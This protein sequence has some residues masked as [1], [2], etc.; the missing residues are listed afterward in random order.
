MI[1]RNI[2]SELLELLAITPTVAILGPRQ[3]GKTTLVKILEKQFSRRTIY[4]D[5][6]SPQDQI[7]LKDAEK[8]LA[9]QDQFLVIIDE[10]QRM[11]ELFPLLR[12]LIDR[13]REDGRFILLGSASPE[14]LFKSAESL[15]GRISYLELQSLHWGEV[16]ELY[17][18]YH[19]WFRGGFPK[20]LLIEKDSSFLRL[21]NDF[22]K[23]YTER[24][25]PLL[26]LNISSITIRNL[27]R[28]LTS[29]HGNLL[30]LSDLSRSLGVSAPTANNYIN[31][32]ENAFLIRRL[33][34]YF[35]NINKRIV[36]MPKVYFRDS[37][38]LH[39]LA[40]IPNME[41][42][43]GWQFVGHSWEGYV[44]QQIIAQ[45]PFNITPYFY[46]T[47]DGTEL[48]L[49]LVK[50]IAPFVGFEIKYTN[51]P[52]LTKGTYIAQKDLGNIP[53][54]VVTPSASDFEMTDSITICS[55]A[56]LQG[57]LKVLFE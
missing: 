15:A 9:K 6:E 20:M 13:N 55:M 8:Y 40:N 21:M 30:N 51:A 27:L 48:D 34:P 35:T 50:G 32:L 26:G 10:I 24:D 39:A 3:I 44:V 49:I 56:T 29:V 47:A 17:S 5:L 37:G 41:T 31:Y 19:H 18:Y 43:E 2:T 23:T 38:L 54:F 22:I 33:Y 42:L 25:L 12:S 53:V 14:L 28:M 4:L 16:S 36:K 52:K 11:P 57:H 46:R 1:E 7:K 45:L